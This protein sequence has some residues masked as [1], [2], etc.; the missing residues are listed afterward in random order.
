MHLEVGERV[1]GKGKDQN[2]FS[3]LH[4]CDGLFGWGGVI[5]SSLQPLSVVFWKITKEMTPLGGGGCGVLAATYGG[6]LG[7]LYWD[8][9]ELWPSPI[10]RERSFLSGSE[11]PSLE[12][13]IPR[14]GVLG[15][16]LGMV[17]G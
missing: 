4:L 9:C 2:V 14:A 15:M 17:W 6:R 5:F 8:S 1:S 3:E 7:T 16:A 13:M 11:D 10:A 12:T